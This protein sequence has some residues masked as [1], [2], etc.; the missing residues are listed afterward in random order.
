[1]FLPYDLIFFQQFDPLI[2]NSDAFFGVVIFCSLGF[3]HVV[4]DPAS[5]GGREEERIFFQIGIL[6]CHVFCFREQGA[7]LGAFGFF[8]FFPISYR[9]KGHVAAVFP[10]QAGVSE[11]P[12]LEKIV[13]KGFSV[14][15]FLLPQGRISGLFFIKVQVF[16]SD[17]EKGCGK[18]LSVDLLACLV[19]I[20]PVN[21]RSVC[22]GIDHNVAHLADAESAVKEMF[23]GVEDQV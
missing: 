17:V 10:A 13:Q 4:Q 12:A 3:F 6:S 2:S 9:R 21:L 5:P 23:K 14:C 22:I 1:M 7:G 18:V 11:N 20:F 8:P 16:L 15:L 19:Q